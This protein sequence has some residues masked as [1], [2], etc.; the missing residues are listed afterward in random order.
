MTKRMTFTVDSATYNR[1]KNLLEDI[2][3]MYPVSETKETV[4]VK[5]PLDKR[6]KKK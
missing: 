3:K 4:Q 1:I 6:K 2:Q 5:K